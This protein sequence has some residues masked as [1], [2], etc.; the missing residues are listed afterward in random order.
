MDES[1]KKKFSAATERASS[2]PNYGTDWF[3][4]FAYTPV[5][6]LGYEEGIHRRDP[7]SIIKVGDLYYV[8]YTKSVGI[9]LGRGHFGDPDLKLFPWDKAD[10]WYATSPDGIN[11]TERG[12]AVSRGAKGDFD[13]RTV[14]TPDVL[15][16]DDKYYL[17]YQTQTMTTTYTGITENVGMA[18]ASSPDGP[19][20]KVP[21]QI[22]QL[23]VW[24]HRQL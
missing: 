12:C 3:C 10:I 14:C 2:Y 19:W 5:T 20:E 15:A 21:S 24:R 9:F 22:I 4:S 16:H 18:V 7:S 11:W 23:L 13:D 17:V 1:M 8:Y 6:G